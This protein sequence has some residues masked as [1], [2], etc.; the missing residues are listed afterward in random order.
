MDMLT[1]AGD[2]LQNLINVCQ[3]YAAQKSIIYNYTKTEHVV[4]PTASS[5]VN[6]LESTQLCGCA[7][8]FV[9]RFTY[10]DYVIPCHMTV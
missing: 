3:V 5:N 10:L 6:Y 8:I 9:E 4:V 1:P 7:V 2:A